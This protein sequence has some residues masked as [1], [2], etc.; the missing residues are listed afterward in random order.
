[1]VKL[2]AADSEIYFLEYGERAKML[3]SEEY[4]TGLFPGISVWSYVT[5]NWM[6]LGSAQEA[7]SHTQ[8][9]KVLIELFF[10]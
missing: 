2:H 10:M 5:S 6:F 9:I 4:L 8:M 3:E 1:M 7:T